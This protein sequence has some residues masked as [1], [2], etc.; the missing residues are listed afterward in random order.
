MNRIAYY[1]AL[2]AEGGDVKQAAADL[3]KEATDPVQGDKRTAY[4]K[5]SSRAYNRPSRIPQDMYAGLYRQIPLPGGDVGIL[6][7]ED[8]EK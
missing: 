5:K 8:E 4:T 3:L 7:P 2:V 1:I 6:P